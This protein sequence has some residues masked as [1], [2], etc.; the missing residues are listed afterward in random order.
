[1]SDAE[2]FG[3]FFQERAKAR[4]SSF[5]SAKAAPEGVSFDIVMALIV[6][7]PALIAL[8]VGLLAER[9]N[10]LHDVTV[11]PIAVGVALLTLAFFV[12]F[13]FAAAYGCL[14]RAKISI[15]MCFAALL[16]SALVSGS[17][18]S[19]RA[20]EREAKERE[21]GKAGADPSPSPPPSYNILMP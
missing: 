11:V 17:E 4:G 8:G 10:P 9:G 13:A 1:M 16:I 14:P 15:T 3:D 20:R 2:R 7:L 6:L 19:L 12:I 21:S 5:F 18:L